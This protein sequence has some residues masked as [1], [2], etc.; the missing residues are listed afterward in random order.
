MP[1]RSGAADSSALPAL[2][3]ADPLD[4]LLVAG[5]LVGEVV[6]VAVPR[7]QAGRPTVPRLEEHDLRHADPRLLA[8]EP[9][10]HRPR[11][12]ELHPEVRPLIVDAGGHLLLPHV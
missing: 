9:A 2:D 10:F 11:L 4:Q 5:D 7:P 6:F 3:F 12:V 8:V 1:P